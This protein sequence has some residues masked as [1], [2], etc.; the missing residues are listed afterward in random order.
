[1]IYEEAL[2]RLLR[3][4][5]YQDRCWQEVNGK[6]RE[7]EVP[8][9]LWP[10]L[11]EYLAT[12]KYV[13]ERRF[14]AS[15]VR[16]KHNHSGWG[17]RRIRFELQRRGIAMDMIAEALLELDPEAYEDALSERTREMLK[18][19]KKKGNSGWQTPEAYVAQAMTR[20]GYEPAMVW[21]A[22]RAAGG[23]GEKEDEQQESLFD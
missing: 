6:M 23:D 17:R 13:D 9:D 8:A 4:C 21:D 19:R 18:K 10:R 11:E 12:E 7:L 22:I 1:M 3:Y 15:F 16:G 14:A 5:A 20:A 2:P